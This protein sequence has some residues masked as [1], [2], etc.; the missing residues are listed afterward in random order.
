LK[1]SLLEE[2][3]VVGYLINRLTRLGVSDRWQIV[4]CS[5]LRGSYHL[6]QGF[7]G[8]LGNFAMGLA[9]TWAYKKW[10]RL[11]PLVVAHFIL[12]TVSFVGYALIGNQIQL[13]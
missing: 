13:P 6:Y 7:A 3:L 9:F 2:V 10:G 1:A 4:I 8:F 11:S 12:D 5:G